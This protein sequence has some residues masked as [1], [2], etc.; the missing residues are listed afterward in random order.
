[1]I[2]L[3]PSPEAKA[4]L[5][6]LGIESTDTPPPPGL[7]RAVSLALRGLTHR[8]RDALTTLHKWGYGAR[9]IVNAIRTS[10]GEHG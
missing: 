9:D 7:I 1:M 5:Q 3:T 6:A 2:D 8:E 4:A 10:R